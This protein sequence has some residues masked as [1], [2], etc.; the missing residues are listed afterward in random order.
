MAHSKSNN[1]GFLK[2]KTNWN[3]SGY[4]T[5]YH[6]DKMRAVWKLKYHI[7][8]EPVIMSTHFH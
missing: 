3:N 4:F 6:E 5:G 2:I 1:I 8:E 7:N